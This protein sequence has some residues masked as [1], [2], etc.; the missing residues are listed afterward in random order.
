MR[1]TRLLAIAVM[2]PFLLLE[3]FAKVLW[4]AFSTVGT[5]LHYARHGEWERDFWKRTK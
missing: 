5:M 2:S 1:I 3:G 4:W